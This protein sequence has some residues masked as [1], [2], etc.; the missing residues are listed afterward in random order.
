A[1]DSKMAMPSKLLPQTRRPQS[2]ATIVPD[3][4]TRSAKGQ[5]LATAATRELAA[6]MSADA[7]RKATSGFRASAPSGF[8]SGSARVPVTRAISTR[9]RE[10]GDSAAD[11][12]RLRLRVAR[13][14]SQANRYR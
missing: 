1:T 6:R 4:I 2:Q 9:F 14:R 13:A 11:I 7:T 10:N 5:G 3:A 8:F 12:R